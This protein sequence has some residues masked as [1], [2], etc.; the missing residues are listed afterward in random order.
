MNDIGRSRHGDMDE[1]S[2][3]SMSHVMVMVRDLISPVTFSSMI[4]EVILRLVV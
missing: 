1:A 3:R 2:M 4:L